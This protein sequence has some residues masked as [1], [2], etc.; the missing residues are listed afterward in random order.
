MN[1]G[2]DAKR[3]FL[4]QS[5]LGN[6]SRSLIDSLVQFYPNNKYSLFTT[7]RTKIYAPENLSIITPSSF[8]DRKISS[9][10]RTYNLTRDLIKNDIKIY[11]GLSHELPIGIEKTKI[12]CVVTIHDL[13]FLRYP[14][15]YS[16]IDR[17]IYIQK[18]KRSCNVAHKIIAISEQTKQDIIEFLNIPESKIDVVYQNCDNAFKTLLSADER[19]KVML[20]YKLP[21]RYILSIGTVEERKNILTSIKAFKKLKDNNISFVI[22]GRQKKKYMDLIKQEI[23]SS[24][25]SRVY[26]Y[27]NINFKDF[28]AIYQSA[29]LLLYPSLF[30]GFGIPII[31][32]L[33]SKIPVITSKYGCF[34][35]VGGNNSVYVDPLN[36][37]EIRNA[38]H[39]FLIDNKLKNETSE[40]GYN[41]V[42]QFNNKSMA[43][44]LQ[45]IYESVGN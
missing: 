10:W 24:I 45:K 44:Q 29:E 22:I 37:D 21:S 43:N 27:E 40:K 30:E 3:A 14:D 18:I 28:P 12:A 38:I 5:G 35:E 25:D 39:G 32:A 31:E 4:N 11:H 8:I 13:I 19:K 33:Y 20:R 1:I 23:D 9:Y 6:Y 17:K 15:T 16:S 26:F 2:F 34:P 36:I 41:F 42:Q 7:K